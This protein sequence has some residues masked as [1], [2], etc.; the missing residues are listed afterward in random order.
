MN[1]N[2]ADE[3]NDSILSLD[4]RNLRIAKFFGWAAFAI[5]ISSIANKD[6]A[7]NYENRTTIGLWHLCPYDGQLECFNLERSSWLDASRA[8]MILLTIY[9]VIARVLTLKRHCDKKTRQA[10]ANFSSVAGLFGIIAVSVYSAVS[11]QIKH[12]GYTPSIGVLLGAVAAGSS[13]IA[14]AFMHL[15]ATELLDEV[16]IEAECKLQPQQQTAFSSHFGTV[17]SS[18][19]VPPPLTSQPQSNF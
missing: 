1:I 17:L 14:A 18:H 15:S 7:N 8:F 16:K 9:T 5:G 2:A 3:K 13:C 4:K 12:D 11:P 10:S 6:W 19:Q